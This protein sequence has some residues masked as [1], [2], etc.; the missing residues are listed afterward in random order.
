M[1]RILPRALLVLCMGVAPPAPAAEV[2]VHATR[3]GD[4][5]L[6]EA[7]AAFAGTIAQTWQVLTDY[8]HLATFIP[9]MSVSRVTGRSGDAVTVEQ[10][11][12]A[13]LLFWSYPIEVKLAVTEFPPGK[14][15]SRAVAGSFKEMSGAYELESQAG[16][17]R[18]R[19]SGRVVPGFFMPPLI[20]TWVLRRHVETA[21]GALVDEIVRRQGDSSTAGERR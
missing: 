4:A 16:L 6:I 1:A 17:V 12:E 11:G 15:V 21:F 19:Y 18:M 3:E 13:R 7:S 10:K 20:G 2:L 14:V 8:D 5:L 9:D